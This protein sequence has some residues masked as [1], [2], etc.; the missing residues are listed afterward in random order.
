MQISPTG[1]SATKTALSSLVA[2][3]WICHI[4]GRLPSRAAISGRV[5]R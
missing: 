3:F 2:I 4:W 1:P 5:A